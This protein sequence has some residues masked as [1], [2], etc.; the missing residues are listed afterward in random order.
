LH[1]AGLLYELE[2]ASAERPGQM[3]PRY[4]ELLSG[5]TGFAYDARTYLAG[6]RRGFW[7]ARQLRAWMLSAIL[8]QVLLDRFDSQWYRNPAAGPFLAEILSA[9]QREDGGQLATQLG[10]ARLTPEPLLASV[11]GWLD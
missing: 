1:A 9:G 6:V 11:T 10:A 4:V 7:V 5:A 2:L 3:A 8:H